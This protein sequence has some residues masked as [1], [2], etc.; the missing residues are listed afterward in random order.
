MDELQVA[1]WYGGLPR[2]VKSTIAGWDS[3]SHTERQAFIQDPSPEFR[4]ADAK[5][6]RDCNKNA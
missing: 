2:E 4:A 5:F 6:I 1:H 3:M